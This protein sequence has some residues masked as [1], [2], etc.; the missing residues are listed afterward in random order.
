MAPR[1]E[2]D[3]MQQ[4]N[5]RLTLN[6]ETVRVLAVDTLAHA[7][8]GSAGGDKLDDPVYL[9]PTSTVYTVDQENGQCLDADRL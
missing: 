7:R 8:G 4:R 1:I 3:T 2:G 9:P 5:R 6:R